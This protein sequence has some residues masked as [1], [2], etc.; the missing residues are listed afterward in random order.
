MLVL[1]AIGTV[2][3]VSDQTGKQTGLFGG[4]ECVAVDSHAIN[5]VVPWSRWTS[6][7][8]AM[9]A[10]AA[11]KGLDELLFGSNHDEFRLL[12]FRLWRLTSHK[13]PAKS[14]VSRDV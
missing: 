2:V 9:Q 11:I 3:P 1:G 6:A 10:F 13:T 14:T 7:T 12:G 5:L 8:L 4:T